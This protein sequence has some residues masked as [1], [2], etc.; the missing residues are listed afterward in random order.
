MLS[1]LEKEQKR[2]AKLQRDA[3]K[4][5][6]NIAIPRPGTSAKPADLPVLKKHGIELS[7]LIYVRL[8]DLKDNPLNEYPPLS[9]AELVELTEDIKEKGILIALILKP[10]GTIVC[11]HNR[12]RAGINAGLER[13]PAQ[14]I[15]SLL[16][17]ELERDIMKSE[18]DRRRGG[19]WSRQALLMNIKGQ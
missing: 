8:E 13:G 16:T 19:H 18:N 7:D 17:P 6:A 4:F 11:G 14:Q 5:K 3:L 12:K 1:A 15:L 10:D 2:D 9:D